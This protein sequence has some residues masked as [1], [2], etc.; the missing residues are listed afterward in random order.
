MRVK[1]THPVSAEEGNI[2]DEKAIPED[3]VIKQSEKPEEITP[4]E[5]HKNNPPVEL[6]KT[7]PHVI[8]EHNVEDEHVI[9]IGQDG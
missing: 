1:G 8:E 6:T 7:S 3:S 4:I 9:E 2:V 5:A